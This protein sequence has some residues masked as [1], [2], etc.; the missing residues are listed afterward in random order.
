MLSIATVK[1]AG[2]KA[3][4]KYYTSEFTEG[5][6]EMAQ[7]PEAARERSRWWGPG[8]AARGLADEVSQP[9]LQCWRGR[10]PVPGRCCSTRRLSS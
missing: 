9:A 2:S 6:G 1:G 3:M 4:A 5:V 8:A 10:I 7:T